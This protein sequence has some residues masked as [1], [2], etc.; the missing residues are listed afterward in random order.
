MPSL[1]IHL[2]WRYA[3]PCHGAQTS[4]HLILH[5]SYNWIN[6]NTVSEH[7]TDRNNRWWCRQWES[8][9]R[10]TPIPHS[11][12]LL[13]E[14]D[15]KRASRHTNVFTGFFCACN[16]ISWGFFSHNFSYFPYLKIKIGLWDHYTVGVS[17]YSSPPIQLLNTWINLYEIC[18]IYHGTSTH[19]NGVIHKTPP[20]NLFA[21]MRIHLTLL[22]NGWVKTLS[23][24]RIQMN[25]WK[26]HL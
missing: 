1:R 18:Y 17:V 21:C 16:L 4:L 24:Q 5:Y 13:P 9:K 10:R 22:G 23:L 2:A 19:L 3:F 12:G 6:R 20:V 25:C 8:L 15:L 14:E 7:N 11:H 26:G